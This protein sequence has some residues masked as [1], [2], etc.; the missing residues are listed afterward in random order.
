M[1]KWN[2]SVLKLNTIYFLGSV[3][4]KRENAY[5]LTKLKLASLATPNPKTLLVISTTVVRP[6]LASMFFIMPL[7]HENG[8]FCPENFSTDSSFPIKSFIKARQVH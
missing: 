2:I 7:N 3:F 1:Q 4:N 5:N 6:I 8:D